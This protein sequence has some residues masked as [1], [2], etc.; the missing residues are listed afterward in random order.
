M[1]NLNDTAIRDSEELFDFETLEDYGVDA[2]G[3]AGTACT[4][5]SSNGSKDDSGGG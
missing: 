5:N 2:L 4:N 3:A 1:D